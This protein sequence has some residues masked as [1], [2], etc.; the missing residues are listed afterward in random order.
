[1]EPFKELF[2]PGRINGMEIKNRI[3]M[4]AIG[5]KLADEEESNNG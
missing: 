1:M 2:R 4:A 3:V 5:N